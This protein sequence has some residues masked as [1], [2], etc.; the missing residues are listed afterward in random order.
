[1]ARGRSD[2]VAT[3]TAFFGAGDGHCTQVFTV[4]PSGRVTL[5]L[6]QDELARWSPLAA[7]H[8]SPPDGF[9]LSP[10]ASAPYTPMATASLSSGMATASPTMSSPTTTATYS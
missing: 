9:A 7:P 3:R 5:R 6:R 4:H 10:G 2:A 8:S 1:M